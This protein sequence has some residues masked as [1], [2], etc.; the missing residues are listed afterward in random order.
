MEWHVKRFSL[1]VATVALLGSAIGSVSV[2]HLWLGGLAARVD[3]LTSRADL[4]KEQIG[5]IKASIGSV[6]EEQ[7]ALK[8]QN[9]IVLDLLKEM[10]MTQITATA[11]GNDTNR[12]VREKSPSFYW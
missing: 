10:R 12:I 4:H 11:L 2:A 7:V 5:E 6:R 3:G 1:I 9:T 8:M